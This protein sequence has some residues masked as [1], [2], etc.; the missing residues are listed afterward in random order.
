[1]T[2]AEITAFTGS[3]RSVVAGHPTPDRWSPGSACDDVVPAL[4]R[5]L[6]AAGW[7]DLAQSAHALPFVGPAAAELG[8]GLVALRELDTLLGGSPLASGLTRYATAGELAVL[9]SPGG[10][11][12]VP[13]SA[14]D[15][16]PYGDCIGTR[17]ASTAPGDPRQQEQVGPLAERAWIAATVGYLAGLTSAALQLALTHANNREAFGAPLSSLVSVQQ[18]LAG[19]ALIADSLSL[20]A[21][22]EPGADALSY[23]GPASCAALRDCHQVVG[24]IGFTLEYPLQ[25]YSRRARTIQLWADAWISCRCG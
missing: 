10:V 8:R 9:P 23:A 20:L 11:R 18:R 13:I 24:A 19:A 5:Q 21:G 17:R 25:R 15:C 12:R 6:A 1:M 7:Y 4:Q 22:A 3:I 14:A 16:V 2:S